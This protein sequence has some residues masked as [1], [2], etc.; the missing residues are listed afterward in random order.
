M[1][2]LD[3]FAMSIPLEVAMNPAREVLLATTMN[4]RPLTRDHGYPVRVIVPGVVGA[5]S[6]KWISR[7][8]VSKEE[9]QSVW[10][11]RTY[12]IWPSEIGN[13]K[14][15]ASAPPCMDINVNSAIISHDTGS[16]IHEGEIDNNSFRVSGWAFSGAGNRIIRVEVSPDGGK[17][18]LAAH[19]SS[20]EEVH[21]KA[22]KQSWAWTLWEVN[23]PVVEGR[24]TY[25]LLVRAMDEM[26]NVQPERMAQQGTYNWNKGG[27]LY[28]AYFGVD[29][30]VC[31]DT[32]KQ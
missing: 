19:G 9:C 22:W 30:T 23:I 6:V 25:N 3:G 26:Y 5:R 8:E 7:L 1:Y 24:S 12:R 17:T 14:Y 27:Y 13:E 31:R 10:Q 18:W 29:V 28:N 4:G 32:A 20:I 21:A 15:L 16:T 2:G 11:K